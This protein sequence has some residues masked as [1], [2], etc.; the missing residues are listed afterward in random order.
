M[1]IGAGCASRPPASFDLPAFELERVPFFPQARY[2][3]G[4]AALATMLVHSGVE[5]TP[6]DLVPEVYLP[7]R[8]GSLQIE[9]KAASRRR[10]RLPYELNADLETVLDEASAGNPVL[11]LQNLGFDWLP[12]WHYAVIVGYE[13]DRQVVVLRSGR[14]ARRRESLERFTRS[15]TAAGEWA[16]VTVEPG[17]LPRHADPAAY[18]RA[19]TD[20]EP[21]FPAEASGAALEAALTRWPGNADLAFAAANQARAA[22]NS[23]RATEL[24]RD[25]LASDPEHLGALN[26]YAARPLIERALEAAGDGSPFLPVLEAT[27]EEV[28]QAGSGS[29]E[30]CVRH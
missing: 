20:A 16:L 23:L 9:L 29:E 14:E 7:E 30:N 21:A 3:C 19:V 17:R 12:R 11:V 18:L 28:I 10:G 26:N 1:A 6:D 22:G 15:W 4:P 13:P 27:L 8:R 24:Y 2:Q 5:V 25:A